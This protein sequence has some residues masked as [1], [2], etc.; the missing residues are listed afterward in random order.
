MVG[1]AGLGPEDLGAE[2][3]VVREQ[4]EVPGSAAVGLHRGETHRLHPGQARGD[5]VDE[6]RDAPLGGPGDHRVEGH[7]D[8]GVEQGVDAA[9]AQGEGSA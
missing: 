4:I 3:R 7:R 6:G 8:A 2:R 9:Q 1:S 5:E